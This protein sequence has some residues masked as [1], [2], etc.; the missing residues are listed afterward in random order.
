MSSPGLIAD[1]HGLITDQSVTYKMPN[2]NTIVYFV[3]HRLV[4]EDPTLVS[5]ESWTSLILNIDWSKT[6]LLL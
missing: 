4:S 2:S 3:A 6:N 1:H 5:D